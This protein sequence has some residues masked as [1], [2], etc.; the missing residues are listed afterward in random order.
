MTGEQLDQARA[1]SLILDGNAYCYK[2]RNGNGR[3]SEL[4]YLP[5]YSVTPK[6]DASGELSHYDY[7]TNR[8]VVKIDP[9]DIIH[10]KRGIDPN[11]KL[12][13]FSSLRGVIQEV[14]S[15]NEA[16]T[17]TLSILRNLGITGLVI[18][19][20]GDGT[21]TE[22]E[23]EL[24]K[25]KIKA[26]TTGRHRGE[27]LV[28]GQ[29]I[30]I[31]TTGYSPEQLNLDRIRVIPEARILGAIG[32]PGMALNMTS[33]DDVRT[34]SNYGE[35]R[36]SAYEDFLIPLWRALDSSAA[37][38]LLTELGGDVDTMRV[39]RDLSEVPALAYGV[40]DR[41]IAEYG[42][43]IRKRSE[44][45][46]ELGLPTTPEDDVYYLDAQ[47]ANLSDGQAKSIVKADILGKRTNREL[48]EAA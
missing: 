28:A 14:V 11:N 39:S 19:P 10:T 34:F 6:A 24:V 48:R 20:K 3:V 8:G 37:D 33:G 21:I 31:S 5:H 17:Y 9:A 36:K 2:V 32:I 1:V 26:S 7:T 46:Q 44:A 15:D 29:G 42:G 38:A 40:S 25:A 47:A 18:S 45:R 13:G 12:R 4:Q 27:P 16:T 23:A 41:M 43:G 35:A 30:D 22:E